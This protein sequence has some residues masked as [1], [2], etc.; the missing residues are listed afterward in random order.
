MPVVRRDRIGKRT[1]LDWVYV[2]AM[3]DS[4]FPLDTSRVIGTLAA[5]FREQGDQRL[6]DLL[7]SAVGRI[8]QTG[9]DNWDGGVDI[10]TLYLEVPVEQYAIVE[11]ELEDIEKTIGSKLGKAVRLPQI[12]LNTVAITPIL[13][14]DVA[15][16]DP[17]QPSPPEAAHIWEPDTVRLFLS[18][19]SAHK[20]D[21]AGLKYE[22]RQVGIS[23]FVAHEDVEPSLIWQ[24]EIVLALRT[25]HAMAAVLTP[26]FHESNWTDQE[27]G[28]ALARRVVIIPIRVGLTPYGFM[29]AHQGLPGNLDQPQRVAASIARLLV[30]TRSTQPLMAEALVGALEKA[31]SFAHAKTVTGLLEEVPSLSNDQLDR[32]TAAAK[33]NDQVSGSWGVSERINALVAKHR[34]KPV[35]AADMT[36]DD[37]PF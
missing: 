26:G 24:D 33:D 25:M 19:I 2:R 36:V 1:A 20:V 32:M 30:R 15:A 12:W 34:P 18:H 17:A 21:V 29:G 16:I 31:N 7:A 35:M 4:G 5:I 22:L 14:G 13:S 3:V 10:Y 28:Y 27:V 23:G 9:Y 37:V 11:P 8:E 6:A